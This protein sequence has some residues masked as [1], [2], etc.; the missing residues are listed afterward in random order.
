M[1]IDEKALARIIF[2]NKVYAANGQAYEDLFCAIMSRAFSD[3]IPVKPQGNI[4]DRKNDGYQKKT[5]RY[6]QVYAPEEPNQS[7]ATAIQKAQRDFQGLK[8]YWQNIYPIKEYHFVFNDKFQGPYPTIEKTLREIR[9]LNGLENADVFLAK[10]LED[11]LFSLEDDIIQS[12]IGYIPN[13]DNIEMI[14]YLSI[15]EVIEHI[16]HN[17]KPLDVNTNL[18][19]PD[20]EEKIKFNG[21]SKRIN[22]MLDHASYQL[23]I[24][25]K[26]FDTTG[27]SIKQEIRDRLSDIYQ[28]LK[29]L[30][31]GTLPEGISKSDLIFFEMIK[32]IAPEA[33]TSKSIQDATIVMMAKY[34]EACDIFEEPMKS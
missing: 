17:Q 2:A 13:P 23:G 12:I 10:H 6:Y 11:V 31:F 7:E 19:V 27:A 15:K 8:T 9:E 18:I 33:Q 34:F 26:Y 4:G 20:F 24:L 16:L 3:F 22:A 25:E 28:Q 29:L 21:L 32:R 30:N 5:G 14:D 1:N